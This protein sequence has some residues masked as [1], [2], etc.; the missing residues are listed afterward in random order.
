MGLFVRNLFQAGNLDVEDSLPNLT[1][2]ENVDQVAE[3]SQAELETKLIE[4][5][6]E[7]QA[8]GLEDLAVAGENLE[9]L[10][11]EHT[12][13]IVQESNMPVEEIQEKVVTLEEGVE[14]V[15]GFLGMTNANEL[16]EAL[17]VRSYSSGLN[18]IKHVSMSDYKEGI[19]GVAMLASSIWVKIKTWFQRFVQWVQKWITKTIVWIK[20]YSKKAEKLEKE[21]KE[22]KDDSELK[23]DKVSPLGKLIANGAA[24]LHSI[25][26]YEKEIINQNEKSVKEASSFLTDAVKSGMTNPEEDDDKKKTAEEVGGKLASGIIKTMAGNLKYFDM[27]DHIKDIDLEKQLIVGLD[28]TKKVVTITYDKKSETELELKEYSTK[29]FKDITISSKK[30]SAIKKAVLEVCKDAK[31]SSKKVQEMLSKSDNEWRDLIKKVATFRVS[32]DGAIAKKLREITSFLMKMS[33]LTQKTM[34]CTAYAPGY[35]LTACSEL[36]KGCEKGEDK[37]DDKKD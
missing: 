36:I 31:D 8:S 5:G 19:E 13:N 23:D 26:N 32:G 29:E 3:V 35:F 21:A 34:I 17:G 12:E 14:S 25:L 20:G 4:Q 27:L 7:E 24:S 15:A 16:R 1:T 28:S 30:G 37:K 11:E 9:G 18:S 22:I 6:L 10:V 33:K 2:E